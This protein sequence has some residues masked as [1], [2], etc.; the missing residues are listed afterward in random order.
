MCKNQFSLSTMLV[1][2]VRLRSSRLAVGVCLLVY[3]A[4]PAFHIVVIF[5]TVTR[6]KQRF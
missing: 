5:K 1:P 3:L 2:G 4:G 6:R